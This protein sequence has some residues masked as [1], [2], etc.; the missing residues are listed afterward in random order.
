MIT[1]QDKADYAAY[2]HRFRK[3]QEASPRFQAARDWWRH[4]ILCQ[5]WSD[6]GSRYC[7]ACGKPMCHG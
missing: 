2:W 4:D 1:Q 7:D 3:E 6:T 5:C